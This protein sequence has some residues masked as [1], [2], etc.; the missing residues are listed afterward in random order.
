MLRALWAKDH[1]SYHGRFANFDNASSNPK[2]AQAS[3]PIVIGGHSRAAALRAGR[4]G[5]G[6]FPGK[7]SIA[8]LRSLFDFVRQT[9]A[10]AGRDPSTIE[11]T[12]G[13]PGIFGDDPLGAVQEME[14]I[15]VG[16]IIVPA[17][18]FFKPSPA[19][20]IAAFAARL[21]L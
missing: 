1:A 4:L 21:H 12:A 2:P 20:A 3:V 18:A 10:D 9:A 11:F 15:G 7:G 8:E 19:E 5:D 13:H 16:R 14:S 6:F 17:F